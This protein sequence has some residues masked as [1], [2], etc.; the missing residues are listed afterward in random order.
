MV[1]RIEKYCI[2]KRIKMTDQRRVIAQVLS[3]AID[4]PDV[5]E[6]HC[7]IHVFSEC[8]LLRIDAPSGRQ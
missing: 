4:H 1:S 3:E 2:D 7:R 8:S 6:V 5:E